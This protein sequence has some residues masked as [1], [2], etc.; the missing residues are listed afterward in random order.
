MK[1]FSVI[2]LI[3]LLVAC[4]RNP[5]EKNEYD[6]IVDAEITKR[7]ELLNE[8]KKDTSKE[9]ISFDFSRI[10]TEVSEL[11]LLT[12][13]IE[14]S[15]AVIQRANDYFKNAATKFNIPYE[16]FIVLLKTMTLQTIETAI[17]TNEL[18]LLDKILFAQ[19]V[20]SVDSAIMESVY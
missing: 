7:Y 19:T 13:D 15:D 12:K 9:V 5:S 2:G 17:K 16:G 20:L 4:G 11:I 14:N 8:V 1:W 10:H 18:N 6:K 3:L